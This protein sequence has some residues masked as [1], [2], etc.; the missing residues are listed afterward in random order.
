M[1][2]PGPG[3]SLGEKLS[4]TVKTVVAEANGEDGAE[5]DGDREP[6][7]RTGRRVAEASLW[8]ILLEPLIPLVRSTLESYLAAYIAGRAAAAQA[9]EPGGSEPSPHAAAE[10]PVESTETNASALA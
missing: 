3:E 9:P 7:K 2:T 1:V 5:A 4:R 6:A 8:G 10:G